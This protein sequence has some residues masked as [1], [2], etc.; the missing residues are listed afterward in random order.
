MFEVNTK[1]LNFSQDNG[2]CWERKILA[3]F[4]DIVSV[5]FS[6]GVFL[7]RKFS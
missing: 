4:R 6:D 1:S 5:S 7:R 2:D 3:K